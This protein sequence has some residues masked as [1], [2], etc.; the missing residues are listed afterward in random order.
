MVMIGQSQTIPFRL[1]LDLISVANLEIL[2]LEL[3]TF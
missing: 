2:S 3:V 1:N